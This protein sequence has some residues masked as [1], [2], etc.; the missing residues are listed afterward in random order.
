[1]A[2]LCTRVKNLARVASN[3]RRDDG[4][5]LSEGMPTPGLDHSC[6]DPDQSLFWRLCFL[7]T[8]HFIPACCGKM[9]RLKRALHQAGAFAVYRYHACSVNFHRMRDREVNFIALIL[10]HH[11]MN[12]LRTW[13]P[14]LRLWTVS[15]IASSP[16]PFALRALQA[17]RV[18]RYTLRLMGPKTV[19]IGWSAPRPRVNML[20]VVR[21]RVQFFELGPAPCMW[22][23][24]NGVYVACLRK[25]E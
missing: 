19:R 22:A 16:R 12:L 1:M 15:R 7:A 25:R 5:L 3:R 17:E 9:S 6:I 10:R 14:A 8:T 20:F 23:Y 4:A 2:F 18:R 24:R 11:V 21:R 13:R